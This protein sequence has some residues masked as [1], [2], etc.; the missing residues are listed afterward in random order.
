M[1]IL[2]FHN[3]GAGIGEHDRRNL[4]GT[5]TAAGHDVVYCNAKQHELAECL[6]RGCDVAMSGGGDGTVAEL[7]LALVGTGLPLAVLPLGTSN[8]IAHSLGTAFDAE[9]FAAGLSTA[10]RRRMEIGEVEGLKDKPQ[11]F[12]E[13]VGLGA[14]AALTLDS[15]ADD[16]IG[17]GRVREARRLLKKQVEEVEPFDLSLEADGTQ[18]SGRFLVAEAL[19][20]GYAGPRLPL[21]GGAHFGDRRLE[22]VLVPEERRLDFATWLHEPEKGEPPVE[23]LSCRRLEFEWDGGTPLRIDDALQD[24]AAKPRGIVVSLARE[25]IEVLVPKGGDPHA[26]RAETRPTKVEA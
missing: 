11:R 24:P 4:I 12:V 21:A 17:E 5:L 15:T 16:L 23:R 22:I 26:T 18:L 3:P 1:R 25:T 13:A 19:I 9:A 20:H 10:Q 2:L 8:N 7:A 14:I 6:D